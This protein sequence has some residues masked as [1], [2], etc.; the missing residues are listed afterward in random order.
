MKFSKLFYG[1]LFLH[2]FNLVNA[3]QAIT[4]TDGN[5]VGTGGIASSSV[6]NK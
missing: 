3:Q 5:A 1:I 6:G 4:A 2:T